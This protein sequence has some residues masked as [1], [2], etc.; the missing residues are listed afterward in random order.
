MISEKMRNLVAGNST[1]R[2][3]FEEGKRLAAMHGAENV[4][5]FSIGNPSAPPPNAVKNAILDIIQGGKDSEIHAYMN[6]AGYEDMRAVVA[7]H[8]NKLQDTKLSSRNIIMTVGAAGGLNVVLKSIMNP[9]DEVIMFA[10]YFPEYVNYI[11]NF[12]GKSVIVQSDISTFQPDLD[13]FE[14]AVTK[15]TKAVI[16][17]SPNN[18]T[19]AVYSEQTIKALAAILEAKQKEFSSQIYI[20]SDEPYREIVYNNAF[21]PYIT[22]Y[23]SNSLVVYSY[24]KSLSLPGAR[25]G[26]IVAPDELYEFETFIQALTIANRIL[27][28]VNAPGL[29]QQVIGKCID[30]NVDMTVYTKNMELLYDMFERLG[31]ECLKPE[32]TF[33]IFP[34]AINNDAAEF[35]KK[36]AAEHN[37]L[38]VP[39]GAFGCPTHFRLAFCQEFE[40]IERAVEKFEALVKQF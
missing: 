37:M 13:A 33:Y 4:L 29:F 30:V 18:P 2:A 27:G 14:K 11:S 9:V 8:V 16:I 21:I 26:Y 24:S 36:A 1:I 7:G 38:L 10:P 12:D 25:I 32:G 35:C 5:D 39:G 40:K 17:N 15:N 6:N 34:R 28:F 19:G 22:K 23:Y 3:M 31:F 20:V